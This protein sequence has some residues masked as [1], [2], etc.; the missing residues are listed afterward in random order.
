MTV[1]KAGD[2]QNE[3]N[4]QAR[5]DMWVLKDSDES[6]PPMWIKSI[7]TISAWRKQ[8]YLQVLALPKAE[9]GEMYCDM[10]SCFRE[11]SDEAQFQSQLIS[12]ILSLQ[13]CS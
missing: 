7:S 3:I 13:E 10:L 1:T 12:I 4:L 11:I 5:F 2:N 8:R 6:G 9:F